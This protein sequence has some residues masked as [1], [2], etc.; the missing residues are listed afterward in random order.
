M[1]KVALLSDVH[2]NLEALQRVREDM[3]AQS[4]TR[5]VCLGD[6]ASYNA[7]QHACMELAVADRMEWI[8]G[9]HDLMAAGVLSPARCGADARFAALKAKRELHPTWR[10]HIRR[11]PL[12]AMDE[13]DERF[14]AFHASPRRVDEYLITEARVRDSVA[15]LSGRGLPRVVFFGHTHHACVWTL[16][17]N[18]LVRREGER[19]ALDPGLVHLVNV[20]T[21]GEPRDADPRATWVLFDSRAGTV[22]FRRLDYDHQ[23]A[24]RKA[25]AGGWRRKPAGML[26]RLCDRARRRAA[27]VRRRVLPSASDDSS[28]E[29]IRRRRA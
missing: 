11:L 16:D 28:L 26:T 21:V 6:L 1:P 12:V 29:T 3:A 17:G 4:V 10:A 2:G 7:D 25:E 13:M 18:T 19:L 15:H 27:Q 8:A 20:G 24:R 14:L 9:N 22:E 23:G 5:I